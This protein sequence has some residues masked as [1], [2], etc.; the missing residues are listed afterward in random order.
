MAQYAIEYLKREGNSVGHIT[1]QQAMTKG[2][3]HAS[4]VDTVLGMDPRF[5]FDD[6]IISVRKRGEEI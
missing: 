6:D 1:F 2:G 4:D 5:N 3:Y